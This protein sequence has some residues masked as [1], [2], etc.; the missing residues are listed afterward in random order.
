MHDSIQCFRQVADVTDERQFWSLWRTTNLRSVARIE[1]RIVEGVKRWLCFR[2]IPCDTTLPDPIPIDKSFIIS[3]TFHLISYQHKAVESLCNTLLINN[4]AC[5]G[6][7]TGTGKTYV[8]LSVC[9][10]LS[11]SPAVICKKSGV[12][13][14][15]R[16]SDYM[17]IDPL[18]IVNWEYAKNGKF[19]YAT[20]RRDEYDGS[21][22]Y[23]WQVPANTLLIFDEAHLGNHKG[24][25]NY[26][27]WTASKGHTSL[28]V[29]ATFSDTLERLEGLF[30][31]LK[32]MD[33]DKFNRMLKKM[34]TFES[35]GKQ[36]SL[37]PVEDMQKISRVLYPRYGHRISYE[38][39]EVKK[40]FPEA[41]YNIELITLEQD[42]VKKHNAL[43]HELTEKIIHYRTLGKI[44]KEQQADLLVADLR[45]R[46]AAE[47]LKVPVMIEL[48]QEYLYEGKSV[49]VFVNFRETMTHIAKALDTKSL[50][51]GGQD[52][53][54]INREQVISD[55]QSNKSRLIIAMNDAGGTSIDLH[56]LQGGHQRLSLIC[57]T[58]NPYTLKQVCGRT[59]RAG[60]KT[61]PIIKLIYAAGT[62]EQKVAESVNA[63]IDNIA[64]LNDGDLMSSNLFSIEREEPHD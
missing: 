37:S 13:G 47:L 14:W 10:N 38:D 31:V 35:H 29:S 23:T 57:P 11:L 61:I 39:P 45:Y 40:C 1:A 26:S 48:I 19:P 52:A 22:E 21:Y 24:S 43:Y 25:Q 16:A 27:L 6:S 64:A 33:T 9:R 41:V 53:Y 58:Y 60:S 42:A 62:I 30:S 32:I 49:C 2:L 3:D 56:D 18:F 4:S 20:R 36:Q 51:F 15:K 55:F 59:Y 7:D 50:I 17:R 63:K 34:G 5:D 12:A 8:A 54:K 44:A 46:Q 28:S